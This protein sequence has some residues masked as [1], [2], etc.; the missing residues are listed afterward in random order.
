MEIIGRNPNP[1][2]YSIDNINLDAEETELFSAEKPHKRV[3][4]GAR[5]FLYVKLKP[6]RYLRRRFGTGYSYK[7]KE[8]PCDLK[9]EFGE[10][11]QMVEAL[12]GELDRCYQFLA[13]KGLLG[14]IAKSKRG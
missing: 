8:N 14:D 2:Q 4:S 6:K 12:T 10:L 11:G 7:A 1:D 3:G 9:I 13:Q 5:L